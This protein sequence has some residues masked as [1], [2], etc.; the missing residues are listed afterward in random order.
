M[1]AQQAAWCAAGRTYDFRADVHALQQQEKLDNLAQT[2]DLQRPALLNAAN[3]LTTPGVTFRTTLTLVLPESHAESRE[4]APAGLTPRDATTKDSMMRISRVAWDI[5]KRQEKPAAPKMPQKTTAQKMKE[6]GHKRL[7]TPALTPVIVEVG[8]ARSAAHDMD[9]IQ[10][11]GTRPPAPY[12]AEKRILNREHLPGARYQEAV[13]NGIVTGGTTDTSPRP[14]LGT[15]NGIG[16][17]DCNFA[18]GNPRDAAEDEIKTDRPD[19]MGG[20]HEKATNYGTRGVA[21]SPM[22]AIELRPGQTDRSDPDHSDI[23]T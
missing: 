5:Y 8:A 9:H 11:S 20:T 12:E 2:F 7:T 15:A 14:S 21:G 4:G 1:L 6:I 22:I 23:P 16:L 13:N 17:F 10:E 18:P 3:A 19:G